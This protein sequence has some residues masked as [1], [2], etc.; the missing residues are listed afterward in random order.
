MGK[1]IKM[2]A[3]GCIQLD[4]TTYQPG[5]P[6]T[7]E[8]DEAER[9][10]GLNVAKLATVIAASTSGSSA[11][12]T[13]ADQLAVIAA[14]TSFEEIN[15]VAINPD[16]SPEVLA[17]AHARSTELSAQVHAELLVRITTAGT[18]EE[19]MSLL[20][21]DEPADLAQAEELSAAARARMSELGQE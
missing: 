2:E 12:A 3:I 5:D 16:V 4:K 20:P 15:A 8:A 10:T 9:L 21:Q 7:C 14:A 19:L 13:I 11:A 6:F 1:K 17:A 18:E